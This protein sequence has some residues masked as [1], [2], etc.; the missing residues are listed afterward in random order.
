M[1]TMD[2]KLAARDARICEL[3]SQ[4]KTID[5]KYRASLRYARALTL[6]DP[7]AAKLVTIPIEIRDDI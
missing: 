4:F 6:I 3:E 5:S 7:A 2:A 1:E